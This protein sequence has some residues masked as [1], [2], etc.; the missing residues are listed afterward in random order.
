MVAASGAL[1][2]L[3]E[4][5]PEAPPELLAVISR[6]LAAEPDDRGTAAAFA[7]D[8]RHACRPE[9]VRL[10][11][12]GS[13][14]RAGR[15]A[16][17]AHRTDAPGPPARRRRRSSGGPRTVG[18]RTPR[19]PCGRARRRH[20]PGR[21]TRRA[22][23]AR[24]RVGGA[25]WFGGQLGTFRRAV[26]TRARRTRGSRR[27]ARRI[28]PGRRPGRRGRSPTVRSRPGS[29]AGWRRAGVGAVRAAGAGVHHRLGGRCSATST[30]RTARA[31]AADEQALAALSARQQ[32][33]ARLR[34]AGRRRHR[35]PADRRRRR[36]PAG[37]QLA[38]LR[39]GGTAT[40]R[41]TARAPAPAAGSRVRMDLTRTAAGWRIAGWSGWADD[42]DRPPAQPRA[43]RSAFSRSGSVNEKP[44]AVRAAGRA[45]CPASTLD[46]PNSP[47][48]RRAANPGTRQTVGRCTTRPS[49]AR[50]LG[51]GDRGGR[52]QV[53]R[54]GDV[55]RS[56]RNRIARDLVVQGDP[57]PVLPP[58]AQPSAE[59]EPEQ[60]ASIRASSAAASEDQPGAQRAPPGRRPPRPARWPPPTRRRRRARKSSP[61]GAA[62]STA[63]VARVAVVADRRRREQHR[64]R[65]GSAAAA[66]AN[67][68][69]DRGRA[70]DAGCRGAASCSPSVHGRRPDGGAG[71]VDHGVDVGE[72][73]RVDPVV[74]GVPAVLVGRPRRAADQPQHLVPVVAQ[75]RNQ[76]V[77]MSPEDPVTAI[78]M[79]LPSSP[80]R[81]RA[82]A[83]A[84]R[85]PRSAA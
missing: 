45:R 20:P 44:A 39:A 28:R 42:R 29:A 82:P 23:R 38:G 47:S 40:A 33:A 22:R 83:C 69:A 17:A 36:A 34:A 61:A 85:G 78:F 24:R 84:A 53:H 71:E 5:A 41:R 35:R 26:P 4:L 21:R 59:A 12:A 57:R 30:R 48:A 64:R 62:S 58:G 15:T 73:R 46:R 18:G 8:L 67:A 2:D 70:V 9:P 13:R 49:A 63:P 31:L 1:P 27:S 14:R 6:G 16:P 37:G 3:G 43:V 68:S 25:V 7:L 50:E 77:P 79:R 65:S 55:V 51:V 32:V 75:R 60:R 11:V 72:Q 10:P 81:T 80:E 74:A 66:A 54:S 19:R 52:G 56:S 76:P